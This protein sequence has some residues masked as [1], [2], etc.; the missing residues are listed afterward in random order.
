MSDNDLVECAACGELVD[1]LYTVDD[2]YSVC[3]NCLSD[4]DDEQSE[5]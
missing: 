3:E 1:A 2:M 4:G 5:Y